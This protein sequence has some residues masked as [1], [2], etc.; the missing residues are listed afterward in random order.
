MNPAV[1]G[2]D[3]VLAIVLVGVG[4]Q[5][6]VEVSAFLCH[7]VLRIGCS[8]YAVRTIPRVTA[9][10]FDREGWNEVPD[11]TAGKDAI[12]WFFARR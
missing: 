1:A 11:F 9:K 2:L 6:L 10:E 5:D 4:D 8:G 7:L 3:A 12:A